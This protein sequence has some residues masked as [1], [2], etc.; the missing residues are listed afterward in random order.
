MDRDQL[1]MILRLGST[2]FLLLLV[3]G[4]RA[5]T[6]TSSPTP[7]PTQTATQYPT[8][9]GVVHTD[10]GDGSAEDAFAL[11]AGATVQYLDVGR[12]VG[13]LLWAAPQSLSITVSNTGAGGLFIGMENTTNEGLSVKSTIPVGQAQYYLQFPFRTRIYFTTVGTSGA[14]KIS[15]SLSGT[16]Q[17]GP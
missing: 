16:S 6:P 13:N 2:L 14:V 11:P 12:V 9:G 5:A 3:T 8:P 10:H 17:A 1:S 4:L 15:Y 7:S